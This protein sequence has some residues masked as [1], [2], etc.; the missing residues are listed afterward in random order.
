M[1]NQPTP[2]TRPHTIWGKKNLCALLIVNV[3]QFVVFDIITCVSSL[4]L[5]NLA[6]QIAPKKSSRWKASQ[7]DDS[8]QT[9]RARNECVNHEWPIIH[10]LNHSIIQWLSNISKF[11]YMLNMLPLNSIINELT[12]L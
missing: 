2:D 3:G 10:G 7:I 12:E 6:N 8:L 1:G 4:H 5:V 9:K 11:G